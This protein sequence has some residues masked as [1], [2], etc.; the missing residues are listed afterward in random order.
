MI[1]LSET[2]KKIVAFSSGALLVVAGP[3]SGKTRVVTERIRRILSE[4]E[5]YFKIL[6]LTFTNKAANEMKERLVEFP[7]IEK[8][9]FI[10]TLHSFCMEVLS[11]RGKPVGI[12]SLPNIFEL[13]DDRKYILRQAVSNEPDLAYELRMQGDAKEQDKLLWRWLEMIS[14]A[15]NN[16]LLPEMIDDETE[17]KVYQA[18]N[19]GLRASNAVDYDDLLLLTYRLFA[20]RVKIAD[21]YR[22][23][24]KYICID[25]SQDLNEAQYQILRVLCGDEYKNVMMVGDPKQA[26]YMWNGANPKYL[27]MFERDFGATKIGLNDNYRCSEDVVN[28][29]IKLS[30][31]YSVEGQLPIKGEVKLIV[32]ISE[33]DEADKVLGYIGNMLQT[34]HPDIE[35]GVSLN[36]CAILARN[37]Y[38]FSEIERRL[39]DL[40]WIYY[41]Q[42]T[43]RD[44]YESSLIE[45]FILCIRLL[46]NPLDKIHF[47][48]LFKRWDA[49]ISITD[50]SCESI[51]K[52]IEEYSR[53]FNPCLFN[54][55]NILRHDNGVV[56]MVGALDIIDEYAR[57]ITDDNER[58]ILVN[59][60]L[61]FRKHWDAYV[62]REYGGHHN[63][64]AFLAQMALGETQQARQDGL[65]LLTVH[66]SKGLEFDVVVVIGLMEGVF[67]D[68]R[69]VG[70]SLEEEKRN[71]F[72]AITRSRRLLALS[73]S[74]TKKMPWGDIKTQTPSRYLHDI[75]SP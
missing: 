45:E 17:S 23:Q 18:Y 49:D 42:L 3:G 30:P 33:G 36:N 27:D 75:F 12:H 47:E 35:I 74:K 56:N 66:S 9:T 59:D 19:A 72:V 57:G 55:V 6:A 31:G 73:Y 16:L 13:Y 5:G 40:G 29:A 43:A 48:L 46:S 62:R 7:D 28:V 61:L 20:E 8:R 26:I 67:P 14:R 4:E 50:H 68:F 65:A 24:Y 54:A 32:G 53:K 25:E 37:R 41:K 51:G 58:E 1:R 11:N 2:Q 60:V 10:G 39:K 38:V 52:L 69:A 15:K 63:L 21:F 64:S 22:R 34:G 71:M 70:P 44:E